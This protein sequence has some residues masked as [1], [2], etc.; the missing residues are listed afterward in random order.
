[1]RERAPSTRR[2][3]RSPSTTPVRAEAVRLPG[4]EGGCWL[5]PDG[6]DRKGLPP[7]RDTPFL[8]QPGAKGGDE[9]RHRRADP[10]PHGAVESQTGF[11]STGPVPFQ[12]GKGE[13]FK[14]LPVSL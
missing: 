11:V 10:P 8:Q 14:A 13:K 3:I 2:L 4:G 7:H 6:K 5:P 9:L 1:M 12:P